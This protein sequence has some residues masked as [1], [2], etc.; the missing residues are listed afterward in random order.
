MNQLSRERGRE[1]E[2][3]RQTDTHRS[4]PNLL[5]VVSPPIK[6][7]VVPLTPLFVSC[8]AERGGGGVVHGRRM[9]SVGGG[10]LLFSNPEGLG[11]DAK[12]SCTVS[13]CYL[14]RILVEAKTSSILI[15]I[16]CQFSLLL[17]CLSSASAQ[18]K[19]RSES[20]LQRRRRSNLSR[21][22]GTAG[23]RD[24]QTRSLNNNNPQKIRPLEAPAE[25]VRQPQEPICS[26]PD[27]TNHI[28][29]DYCSQLVSS[30]IFE[31]R[32]LC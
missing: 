18:Q 21:I 9:A 2:R 24:Q 27:E 16:A 11:K 22:A 1:R 13:Q 31:R 28:I 15:V 4:N 25:P 19:E 23:T 20:T 7:R 17:V 3:V 32:S 6:T 10:V 14:S 26:V 12:G 30:Q 8:V 29:Y 5:L